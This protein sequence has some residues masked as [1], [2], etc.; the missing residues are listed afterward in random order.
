MPQAATL[1]SDALGLLGVVDPVESI[2]PEDTALGLRVLNRLIDALNAEQS[3]LYAV[4]YAT[5]TLPA[6]TTSRTIGPTGDITLSRPLRVETGGYASISGVDYP[7][8]VLTREQYA[9][10]CIKS[11]TSVAPAGVYM[12]ASSP[13]CT[14]FFVLPVG[15]AVTINLP[16]AVKLSTFAASTTSVTLPE[17]YESLFVHEL[18]M[19]LSPYYQSPVSPDIR[20]EAARMRRVLKRQNSQVPQLQTDLPLPSGTLTSADL[21]LYP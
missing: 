20:A 7:I 12:Q 15:T 5:F 4:E 21:G 11:T 1:I 8:S 13:N 10:V 14:L 19:K 18:A 3:L 17:G 9:E 6:S 16:F 2:E